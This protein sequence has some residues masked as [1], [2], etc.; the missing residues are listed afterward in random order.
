MNEQNPTVFIVDDESAVRDALGLLIESAGLSTEGFES[1]CAFLEAYEPDRPGCVLL[2]VRMKQMSGL[3]LQEALQKKNITIPIIFISGHGDVAIS[4]RAF[5][6]GAVDFIEKPFDD[7]TILSRID[8]ALHKDAQSREKRAARAEILR[9]YDRLTPREKEVMKLVI[10]S[11]SNKQIARI[12]GI[13]HRTVD[14]HR[15]RVMEKMAA[16]SLAELIAMALEAE[17]R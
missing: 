14:A 6:G 10:G 12:L 13:S 11:Q 9:R 3:D 8:E 5:R 7:Q 17:I 15:A 16:D 4:A 2:D 1:A